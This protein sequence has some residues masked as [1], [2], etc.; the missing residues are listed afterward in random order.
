MPFKD[1]IIKILKTQTGLKTINLETPQEAFGD[2]SFPCFLLAKKLKKSPNEIAL[3]LSK[4]IKADFLEKTETK[5]PYL[6]FFIKKEKLTELILKK[7]QKEKENYG[8]LKQNKTIL[9]ESPGPNTNK[10][11]HVGHLRNMA[12]GIS[13]SN[14]SKK[15]GN[16][17][18]NIDI[19]NDRGIHI[20]KSMLAYKLYGKNKKPSKKTDHFV[21]DFYVLYSQKLKENP[22]LEQQAKDLLIKWENKDKETIILWKKMNSWALEG[23]YQTYTNFGLNIKKTYYESQCYEKGKEI[24]LN[25]LKKGL[26]KKEKDNSISINLEKE[27]LGKKILL[28]SNGTSVYIT[29][30]IYLAKKRYEDFKMDKLIYIVASEQDYHFKV[31]FKI[32]KK[33]K[34]KFANNLYHLSYGMVNLVSGKMKSREGTIVDAD[35]LI[36]E[37]TNLTKKE[38]LKRNKNISK[39]ELEQRSK[40]IALAAIKFYLLKLDPKKD[41]IFKPEESISFEG[42]T[43]PYI[44][45]SYARIQSILKKAKLL[46]KINYEL[47][48]NPLEFKL[49]KQLSLFPSIVEKASQDLKP[50]LIANYVFLLSKTFNEY[51]HAYNILKEKQEIKN[52]RLTLISSIAITLKISLNLLGIEVLDQM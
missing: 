36:E 14:I 32:L 45:Y 33:L 31:L 1:K 40:I 24:I 13:L 3:G 30:D 22:A 47:L 42:E 37:I 12:L 19:V 51:Y 26:F 4:K 28:R 52:A 10:P 27:N 2:Y 5:G 20:C 6:N 18:K 7:I 16:K 29:Q 17:A 38:I 50:N 34:Y 11:L 8:S 43:G 21:G 46:S 39:K 35:N 25:N 44:Q 15:L 9:I 41:T 49:I 23:M 48:S